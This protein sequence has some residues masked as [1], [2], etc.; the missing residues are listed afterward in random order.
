VFATAAVV[1]AGDGTG[2][3]LPALDG[4]WQARALAGASHAGT[5]ATL[6]SPV[7]ALDHG[8]AWSARDGRL[9]VTAEAIDRPADAL[10]AELEAFVGRHVGTLGRPPG[11]WSTTLAATLDGHPVIGRLDG[12]PVAVAA[13]YG[14]LALAWAPLAA[15]WAVDSLVGSRDPVPAAL[16]PG[17][18]AEV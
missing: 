13:G 10:A 17:R 3:L 5:G 6:P 15:E 1:A 11:H 2:E 16:R 8:L 14:D 7:R 18:V 4:L 9:L 12:V